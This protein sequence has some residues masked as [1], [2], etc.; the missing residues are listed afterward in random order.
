MRSPSTT[1]EEE[2]DVETVLFLLSFASSDVVDVVVVGVV[3]ALR[4]RIRSLVEY[5]FCTSSPV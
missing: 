2:V 4:R 5:H 1:E 3:D